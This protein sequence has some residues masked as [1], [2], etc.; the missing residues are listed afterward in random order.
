MTS[1]ILN[2]LHIW[3]GFIHPSISKVPFI[4]YS[5]SYWKLTN[6]LVSSADHTKLL[7]RVGWSWSAL[8]TKENRDVVS[9]LLVKLTWCPLPHWPVCKH[10]LK[11]KNLNFTCWLYWFSVCIAILLTTWIPWGSWA[12][13][14][15]KKRSCR[16]GC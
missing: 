16:N 10:P 2:L 9:R 13:C 12:A 5:G 14:F 1:L 4:I 15:W 6:W 11:C 8:A 3:S 7:W